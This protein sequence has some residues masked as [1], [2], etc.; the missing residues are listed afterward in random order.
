DAVLNPGCAGAVLRS[1]T[2]AIAKGPFLSRRRALDGE[3]GHR[4]SRA[5]SH[6]SGVHRHP[7]DRTRG[8]HLFGQLPQPAVL[9]AGV[10]YGPDV[11]RLEAGSDGLR[12]SP[13]RVRHAGKPAWR[14]GGHELPDVSV[15]PATLRG[16][17]RAADAVGIRCPTRPDRAVARIATSDPL[18]RERPAHAAV[19]AARVASPRPQG[20][21]QGCVAI[22]TKTNGIFLC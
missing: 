6:R 22:D 16:A 18:H 20:S 14:G 17:H 10:R 11:S 19:F 7:A 3:A 9:R 2:R 15:V 13:L 8:R 1:V 5:L 4:R 21:V 12:I